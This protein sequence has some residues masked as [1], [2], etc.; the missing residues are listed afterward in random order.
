MKN[1]LRRGLI[2]VIILLFIGLS[3]TSSINGYIGKTSNQSS[4][5][6]PANFPFDNDYVN[7]Y[8]KFDDGEGNIAYDSSGHDYD[9]TIYGATWTTGYSSYALDFDGLN[10]YVKLDNYAQNRLG[11]NKTDDL[12]FSFYFNSTSTD[13]G[14][15]FSTSQ[16]L[17]YNPGAHVALNSDG[18]LEF[19]AYKYGC[20]V[21]M[22][23]N[24]TYN[25]G[26]W[27]HVEIIYNGISSNPTVEL[28]VDDEFDTN[29][30]V[31]VCS[32]YADEF[33]K[34]KIGRRSNDT[35]NYFDG[36]IDELKIV[37]YPGGNQ[38][39]PPNIS[40]PTV[41]KP[42]VEYNFTFVTYDPEGDDIELLIINWGDG[43]EDWIRGPI[44][45][46]E[47][48]TLRYKWNENGTYEIRAKSEDYWGDSAWSKP[49]VVRIGN[50]APEKPTIAGPQFGDVGV[51]YE[52][53]FNTTDF[54]KD[55]VC[56]FIDWGDNKTEWTDY[57][58][59]GEE[60]HVRHIW[61]NYGTYEIRA[62]A[63]DIHGFEGDWS[64]PLVVNIT[65]PDLQIGRIAGGLLKITTQINNT[66]ANNATNVVA[67]FVL[68]G[69]LILVGRNVSKN[70]GTIVPGG[71]ADV[72]AGPVLG[73]G[74]VDINVTASANSIEKVSK[75]A[76]GLILL[77][78]VIIL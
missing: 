69:G 31:W 76:K 56:Y 71:T 1:K 59:S 4:I 3:V 9:G 52:Y 77:F 63:K 78:F 54:E 73:F 57:Y 10:D 41:G 21:L 49:Y 34:A 30:T 53:A 38:Q 40:G 75:T 44:E 7:G 17:I 68:E 65:A 25:D 74:F 8:W 13:K 16:A 62:K 61:M 39:S 14:I 50:Q 11:F 22:K 67:S 26:D 43:N 2:C 37:K 55:R 45:S 5:K 29:L 70:L 46:G 36:K 66:G 23:S 33:D 60:V 15:I 18:T 27:H 20:G 28:Y 12:I 6:A 19:K 51:E 35:T 47:E 32:F 24:G 42:G 72:H 48:V 64:D 58:E